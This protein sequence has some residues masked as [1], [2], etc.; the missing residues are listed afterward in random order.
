MIKIKPQFPYEEKKN[1]EKKDL[2]YVASLGKIT[3]LEKSEDPDT[4]GKGCG[5]RQ[6]QPCLLQ[7]VLCALI[8]IC[9]PDSPSWA[10]SAAGSREAAPSVVSKGRKQQLTHRP[11]FLSLYPVPGRARFRTGVKKLRKE[12][13]T[14]SPSKESRF[15]RRPIKERDG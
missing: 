9:I 10:L 11:L 4:T 8:G 15:N 6:S 13:F 3:E 5:P 12:L 2:R 1:L 14:M 7:C